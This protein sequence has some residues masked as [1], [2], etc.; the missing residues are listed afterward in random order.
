MFAGFHSL[1]RPQAVPILVGSGVLSAAI[2]VG[3]SLLPR[4][5][6]N[7]V[8]VSAGADWL[9]VPSGW[10]DTYELDAVAV[11]GTLV[12][13]V[14]LTD[15]AGRTIQISVADLQAHQPLWDLVHNGLLHSD[16]QGD[17]Q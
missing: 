5:V 13:D 9:A 16:T 15:T 7:S 14:V 8:R 4:G 10:V 12:P 6:I 11:Q 2:V 17:D 1:L 3:D